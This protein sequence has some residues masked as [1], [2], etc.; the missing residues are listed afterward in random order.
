M[1]FKTK[2]KININLTSWREYFW[3]NSMSKEET[4]KSI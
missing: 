1:A 2:R 3:I 4:H